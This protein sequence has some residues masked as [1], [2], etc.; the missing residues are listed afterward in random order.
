VMAYHL[1]SHAPQHHR[2]AV[3]LTAAGAGFLGAMGV[4]GC[5]I[6]PSSMKVVG[7]A[8]TLQAANDVTGTG[9]ANGENEY[10][11]FFF[12]DG[13]IT[14]VMR[15]SD[16][17]VTQDLVMRALIGGPST[18]DAADGFSS[19]IPNNLSVVSYTAVDQQ[20]NY[21]YSQPLTMAEKAEIVCTIQQDLGAPTVGTF[22]G[23]GQQ[24]WNDCFDFSEDYGAPAI[25]GGLSSATPS[26]NDSGD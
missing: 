4:A 26:D 21:Q 11:L 8:P 19:V 3:R 20:W 9:N 24:L 1:P 12:R 15:Y 16:D 22:S 2:R 13:K 6:Q 14:P 7:A 23:Q 25:V 18:S 5:G 10:E 17:T